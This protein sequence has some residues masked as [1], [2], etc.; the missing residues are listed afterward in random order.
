ML[1]KLLTHMED[2]APARTLALSEEEKEWVRGFS[3]LSMKPMIYAANVEEDALAGV[4]DNA[5]VAQVRQAAQQEGAEVVVVSA[6]VEEELSQLEMCIRDR[7]WASTM[8]GMPG[9]IS[10]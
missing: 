4:E 5:L 3:L 9:K 6:K 7:L 2:G 10:M 1:E 8:T